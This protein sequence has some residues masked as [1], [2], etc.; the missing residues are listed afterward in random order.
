MRQWGGELGEPTDVDERAVEAGKD[1][2][3]EDDRYARE[4]RNPQ[5]ITSGGEPMAVASRE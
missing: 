2:D 1:A 3:G 4:E 5:G